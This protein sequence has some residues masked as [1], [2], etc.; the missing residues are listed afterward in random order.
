[1]SESILISNQDEFKIKK[2]KIISGGF[3]NLHI[4]IDF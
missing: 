2:Q 3:D 1:M 4:V